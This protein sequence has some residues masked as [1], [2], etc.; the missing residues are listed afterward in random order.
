MTFSIQT[1]MGTHAVCTG[2][3]SHVPGLDWVGHPQGECEGKP[4][5]PGI[6]QPTHPHSPA[7]ALLASCEAMLSSLYPDQRM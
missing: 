3:M 2:E 1:G 5:Y 4:H 7:S 6:W